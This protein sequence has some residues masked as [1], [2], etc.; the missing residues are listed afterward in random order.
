MSMF[1]KMLHNM[2]RAGRADLD[3]LRQL[4]GRLQRERRGTGGQ[5]LDDRALQRGAGR[6]GERL[7]HQ[8]INDIGSILREQ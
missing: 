1:Y 3:S 6:N 8:K 5:W 7:C 2:S 4:D